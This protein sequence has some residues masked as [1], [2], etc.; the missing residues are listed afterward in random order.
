MAAL[1]T[2]SGVAAWRRFKTSPLLLLWRQED[3]TE[4]LSCVTAEQLLTQEERERPPSA[5]DVFP[6]RPAAALCRKAGSLA[7]F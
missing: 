5:P 6:H 4:A 7:A 1:Q 3:E 2:I